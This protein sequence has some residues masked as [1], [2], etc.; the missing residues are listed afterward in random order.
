MRRFQ[1]DV[2]IPAQEMLRYYQGRAELVVIKD[3][4]G[5]VLHLHPRYLRPHMGSAGVVGSFELRLTPNGEFIELVR[6]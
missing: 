6:I 4:A 5:K 3:R 1:F 2:R